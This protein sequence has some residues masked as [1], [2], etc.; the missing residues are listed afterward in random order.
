M[1]ALPNS[2]AELP[3]IEPTDMEIVELMAFD[4][5]MAPAQVVERLGQLDMEA[6]K[7]AF[8]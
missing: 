5:G 1:T 7:K 2:T 6:L 8:P 3:D 4:F